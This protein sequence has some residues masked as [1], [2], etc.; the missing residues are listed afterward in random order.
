LYRFSYILMCL[1]GLGGCG[2]TDEP[3]EILRPEG[4]VHCLFVDMPNRFVR[5][6]L[7]DR[8]SPPVFCDIETFFL[9]QWP[10]GIKS[11]PLRFRCGD[12]IK[13]KHTS[14][15]SPS[16]LWLNAKATLVDNQLKLQIFSS[17]DSPVQLPTDI[18]V[19]LPE[20]GTSTILTTKTSLPDDRT[21]FVWVINAADG[22]GSSSGTES[23]SRS[24]NDSRTE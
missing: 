20:R 23:E 12:S 16:D 21:T 18:R 4:A 1:I 11:E 2:T 24:G 8:E 19:I 10:G 13:L 6:V 7:S 22:D 9:F 3:V 5:D 14:Q 17:E 15:H